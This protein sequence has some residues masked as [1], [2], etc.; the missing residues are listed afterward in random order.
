MVYGNFGIVIKIE[1]RCM[2]KH[3]NFIFS[4]DIPNSNDIAESFVNICNFQTKEEALKFVKDIFGAN[5][6][7]KISLISEVK[8]I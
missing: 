2:N 5:E 3:N 4:V 6:E 7:G 1:E 8:N